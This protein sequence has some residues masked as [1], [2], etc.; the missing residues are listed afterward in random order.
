MP[1]RNFASFFKN[2]DMMDH[3]DILAVL[4]VIFCNEMGFGYFNKIFPRSFICRYNEIQSHV[5]LLIYWF[6]AL[7]LVNLPRLRD[8][9]SISFAPDE[10]LYPF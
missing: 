3:N 9:I 10:D 8:V 6:K 1:V 5:N 4:L 2:F 7:L